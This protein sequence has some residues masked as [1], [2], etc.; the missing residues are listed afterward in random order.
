[1]LQLVA[2]RDSKVLELQQRL[3]AM[4]AAGQ[5]ASGAHEGQLVQLVTTLGQLKDT[6]ASQVRRT[7][8][9]RALANMREWTSRAWKMKRRL[10]SSKPARVIGKGGVWLLCHGTGVACGKAA[11]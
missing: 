7:L 11:M 6:C 3:A 9:V 10:S 2:A 5:E 1:M 4:T 8:S